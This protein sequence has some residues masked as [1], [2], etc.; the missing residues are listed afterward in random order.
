MKRLIFLILC[1]VASFGL[2]AQEIDSD[3]VFRASQKGD[4]YAK[5]NLSLNIPN[6]P[7]QLTLGGA[8]TLG[9]HVFLT[10]SFNLGG[11]VS[12]NYLK[13]I[14]NNV[15]YFIPF[16]LTE[17]FEIALSAAFPFVADFCAIGIVLIIICIWVNHKKKPRINR[18]NKHFVREFPQDYS[19]AVA[20]LL[21][22]NLFDESVAIPATTLSLIGKSILK[23]ENKK[24]T[25][26]PNA[27]LSNLSEHEKYLY[28]CF[29]TGSKISP[30]RIQYLVTED[31][32]NKGYIEKIKAKDY[33]KIFIRIFVVSMFLT[34]LS[35]IVMV[36]H[37][38]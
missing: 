29:S 26:V 14:G 7:E 23:Y 9:Y 22:S 31:A 36:W 19:V 33:A 20:S 28:W 3:Y 8:G 11:D 15:F 12:F 10:D 32:V 1:L 21:V 4:Q 16:C 24:I 25:S 2:F 27:D 37:K 34:F 38:V 17:G 35:L 30:T 5:L 18:K 6:K 13:T